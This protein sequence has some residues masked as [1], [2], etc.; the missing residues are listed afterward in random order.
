MACV[1][2][3]YLFFI[4]SNDGKGEV[5]FISALFK[6]NHQKSLPLNTIILGVRIPTYEFEIDTDLETWLYLIIGRMKD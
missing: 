2:D 4:T 6:S 5:S 3:G 1:P